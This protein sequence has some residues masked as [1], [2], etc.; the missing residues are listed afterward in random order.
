MLFSGYCRRKSEMSSNVHL[1]IYLL[2]A[3]RLAELAENR[4]NLYERSCQQ[5]FVRTKLSNKL[6]IMIIGMKM[7]KSYISKG[8]DDLKFVR[9]DANNTA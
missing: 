9:R 4:I 1:L 5:I 7:N 3:A 8:K 2:E 6:S